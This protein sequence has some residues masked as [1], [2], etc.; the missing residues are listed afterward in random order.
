MEYSG[1]A[2]GMLKYRLSCSFPYSFFI[3]G[4]HIF[5]MWQIVQ[6]NMWLNE[7]YHFFHHSFWNSHVRSLPHKCREYTGI[8]WITDTEQWRLVTH[9]ILYQISDSSVSEVQWK[10]NAKDAGQHCAYTDGNQTAQCWICVNSSIQNTKFLC[11][12]PHRWHW[13]GTDTSLICMNGPLVW[14]ALMILRPFIPCSFQYC[15]LT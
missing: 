13:Y 9:T 4:I 14:L 2:N 15:A 11:Q 3:Y 6:F 7:L 5:C 10:N 8:T 12:T 1:K